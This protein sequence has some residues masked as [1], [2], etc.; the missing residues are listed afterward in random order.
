MSP[1]HSIQHASLTLDWGN[2]SLRHLLFRTCSSCLLRLIKPR[3]HSSQRSRQHTEKAIFLIKS[4][5]CVHMGETLKFID[6]KCIAMR[7]CV[8]ICTKIRRESP[9]QSIIVSTSLSSPTR[10]ATV[11]S[12]PLQRKLCLS[13]SQGAKSSASWPHRRFQHQVLYLW[14]T[15]VS[16][17]IEA[18]RILSAGL[19][20]RSKWVRLADYRVSRTLPKS[21]SLRT[22]SQAYFEVTIRVGIR[23]SQLHN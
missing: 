7:S 2:K 1:I 20:T 3:D 5:H 13:V 22:A 19:R 14:R 17:P 16:S 23:F 9:S 11:A 15:G 21:Q 10:C 12:C 4:P 18:T 6:R 8:S